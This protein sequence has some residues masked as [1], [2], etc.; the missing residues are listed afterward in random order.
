MR[1]WTIWLLLVFLFPSAG[2]ASQYFTKIGWLES[3]SQL[4]RL[5]QFPQE[6]T[7]IYQDND[8][9]MLWFDLQQSSKL[10]FQLEI[11]H[12][13]GFSSLF[14]R[15]LNYLQFYRKSNR[16]QEYD[17]LATDTLLLYLSYAQ[18]A[19]R[20]GQFWFFD[21]PLSGTLPTP[22]KSTLIAVKRGVSQQQLGELIEAYTPDSPSYQYL[23]DTYL[24]LMRFQKLDIPLYRQSGLTKIGANIENRD[25]LLQRLAIVDIDL[26]D[27]RKDIEWFDQSLQ[28]AVKQFQ[29]LHGLK[30][31]GVIGP[32]TLKWI[33]MP[34]NSRL[35]TLAIN[36]E[37]VR[38]W[39]EQRNTIIVVNVPSFE[40]TYWSSGEE[41]F[42]S[43][44]VVGKTERPTPLMITKL[45]SLI[46][47]PSWN[48]PWKIMVEDIIP[49]IQ[50][51]REYLTRQNIKILPKWGSKEEIDPESIDWDNLTPSAFPYRMTQLSGDRNALGLYKFNTPNRR[52]IYLHDTPSKGLFSKQARAF[53]SG[54]IRV[55][56][57]D[58]FAD[59]L[60]ESQ[61]LTFDDSKNEEL[62]SNQSI[63]LKSRIPVH[64]IYQTAW[65]EEG[66]VHYREDIYRLD[67]HSL[68]KG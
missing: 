43:K 2:Y 46:L 1:K 63:P 27:V 54:C 64:I 13:A 52:A 20:E 14:S 49:K 24:H 30:P 58:I 62:T 11:I 32:D 33:N 45:D 5:L 65:Y 67:R 61:G 10:E 28:T 53:S 48:V 34:I 31:D 57:A 21:Q 23:V 51:D 29:S 3:D 60:I 68:S 6:V 50:E 7:T 66:N 35:A 38:Y 22:P 15:Q 17:L 37:R 36:A 12:R 9:Q 18:T 44:V 56:H 25:V 8:D 41:I 16:W 40:M 55:E 39:P 59:R 19:K 26:I 47:N 42:E 4:H